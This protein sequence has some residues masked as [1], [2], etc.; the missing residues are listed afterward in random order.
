MGRLTSTAAIFALAS[1]LALSAAAQERTALVG[2]TLVDGLSPEPIQDSVILVEGERIRAVGREGA[3]SVPNGYRVVS[4]E[5]MTVLPGLWESHAHLMLVG[6]S[7]YEHWNVTYRD[8][9]ADEIMPAAAYQLLMAGVTTARDLGAPLDASLEVRRRIADGEIAGPRLLVS[10]P[11]LQDEP[12]PGTEFFRWGIGGVEDARAKVQRLA[13]AGVDM[14]KLIDHDLMDEQAALAIV[15]EAHAHDLPVIAHSHRPAEIRR[16]LAIGVDGFEHTGL[17]AA[18]GFPDDILELLAERTATGRV[19]GG[20]LFW[21][22]TLAPLWNYEAIT[23]NDEMLDDDCWHDGLRPDTIADIEGSIARPE[24]L[25]YHQLTPRRKPTLARKFAQLREAGVVLLVGTDSGVPMTFHCQST[26]NEL[27]IWVRVMGIDPMEAIP[28][29]TYWP[30]AAMGLAEEVG[31]VT[32]GKFADIIAVEGDALK[33]V[34]LLQRVDFVMT[35]GEIVKQ[36]GKPLLDPPA[37]D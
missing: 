35:G 8:R 33:H 6:H 32:P 24:R 29:A 28:G 27:D 17:A 22:P 1:L 19:F 23:R 15:E 25:T 11:F 14:I 2:G 10:G 12:Y 20:P 9:L 30:A 4:T 31:S 13:E 18:P 26:W 34:N 21:T 36:D 5:G 3:L 16:G 37:P 7:D